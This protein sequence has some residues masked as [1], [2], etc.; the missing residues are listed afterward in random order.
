MEGIVCPLDG[1]DSPSRRAPFLG[2]AVQ[3]RYELVL[4]NNTFVE[5]TC[6]IRSS[7]CSRRTKWRISLAALRETGED[8]RPPELA[9]RNSLA[10]NPDV[11]EQDYADWLEQPT[12]QNCSSTPNLVPFW[13]PPA[14]VRRSWS[15]QDEVTVPGIHFIQEDSA[16]QIGLRWR[17]G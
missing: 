6:R 5:L 15:N 12:Y 7:A 4:K 9:A 3:R 8:C 10:E 17:T 1:D 16:D 13:W 2:I 14:R 11:V